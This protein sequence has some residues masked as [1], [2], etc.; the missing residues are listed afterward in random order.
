[1]GV[2]H[3]EH[4][5]QSHY[6]SVAFDSFN[7]VSNR[8][9]KS[10][11]KRKKLVE[12]SSSEDSFCAFVDQISLPSD[13]ENVDQNNYLT[14]IRPKKLHA[15]RIIQS[16]SNSVKIKKKIKT[17]KFQ[18]IKKEKQKK[19][20]ALPISTNESDTE[21]ELDTILPDAPKK[22]R[23]TA[24]ETKRLKVTFFFVNKF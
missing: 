10:A 19:P 22:K 11:I 18:K 17:E 23:W 9:N 16:A 13:G 20:L 3:L 14:P 21:N 2:S 6:F 12:Y 8:L 15:N 7:K 4:S 24:E 5:K 1:M